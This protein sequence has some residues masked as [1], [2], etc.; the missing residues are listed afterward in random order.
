MIQ[1]LKYYVPN[2]ENLTPIGLEQILSFKVRDCQADSGLL[3]LA[4]SRNNA[5]ITNDALWQI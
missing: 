4:E 1:I 3:N 5:E 2:F